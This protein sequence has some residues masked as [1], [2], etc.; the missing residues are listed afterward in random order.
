[1]ETITLKLRG[2]SCASCAGTIE[3]AL[4]LVPGVVEC[5]VNFGVEQATVVYE[6]SKTN[7]QQ[8]QQ[9]VETVGYHAR[10]LDA[11]PELEDAEQS[12][13]RAESQALTQKIWIGGILSLVLVV[14]SLPAMTGLHIPFIPIWLHNFWL[15]AALTAPVQFWCGREFYVN[16]WKAFKHHAASMDTLIALGTSAAFFYSLWIT[17][18][19]TFL[20]AQGLPAQVYY[21]AC[22]PATRAR[23]ASAR[24]PGSRPRSRPA[25]AS[26][27]TT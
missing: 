21:R 9:A 22:W 20:T 16:A 19:P 4:S 18:F 13:Q 8:L 15:Q 26:S 24:G 25:R 3:R 5:H 17:I 6:P 27:P 10:P 7:P 1:M 2:M 23:V 12:A 11:D 14:G